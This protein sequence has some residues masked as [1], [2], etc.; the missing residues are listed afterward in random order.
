MKKNFYFALTILIIVIL[1]CS[2]GKR[3][4]EDIEETETQKDK[5]EEVK[6]KE[7]EEKV[8]EKIIYNIPVVLENHDV[9]LIPLTIVDINEEDFFGRVKEYIDDSKRNITSHTKRYSIFDIDNLY[10][11]IFYNKTTEEEY[12]LLD[13]RELINNFYIPINPS[14]D[15]LQAKTSNFILYST[16]D[17]DYN[18]DGDIDANDGETVYLCDIY[19]KNK[20][21]ITN[22]NVNL[23]KWEIDTKYD[24]LF[25]LIKEDSDSDNKFTTKDDMKILKTSISNPGMSVEVIRD[26]LRNE[27]KILYE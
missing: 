10:N 5:S 21:Q 15:T 14:G 19:G 12:T 6:D 22:K 23:L 16:I 11:V 2:R 8:D 25:L 7:E 27:M 1:A 17:N 26:S 24:L 3:D 9:V 20:K 13:K 4:D 18:G